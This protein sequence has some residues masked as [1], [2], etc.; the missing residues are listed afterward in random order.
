MLDGIRPGPEPPL[1]DAA[2]PGPGDPAE[3]AVPADDASAAEAAAAA[4]GVAAQQRRPLLARAL[5]GLGAGRGLARA[6]AVSTTSMSAASSDDTE[7][8]VQIVQPEGELSCASEMAL[9]ALW[10]LL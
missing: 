3:R 7:N 8:V 5:P 9:A 6:S 1:P 2:P 10:V 4:A